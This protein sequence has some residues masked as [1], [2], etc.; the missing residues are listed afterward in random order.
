M[1][2]F[3]KNN[4]ILFVIMAVA[5]LAACFVIVQRWNVE[6]KDKTYDIVLDYNEL[7]KL[8][9]QSEN[10]ISWWLNKFAD[11]G[12]DKVG[13]TEES[14]LSLMENTDMA[15]TGYVMDNL[16]QN[17]GWE[18]DYPAEFIKRIEGFTPFDVMVKANGK[19]AVEFV[20]KGITER[21][22]KDKYISAKYPDSAYFLIKGTPTSTLY[23]EAYKYM[24]SKKGGFAERRDIVSSKIMYISLGLMPEKVKYVQEQGMRV[25][26]RTM[27]YGGYNDTQFAEA[28]ISDYEDYNIHPEYIIV[29]GEAVFGFDDGIEFAKDYILDNEVTIGLIENTTQRQNI[30]QNGVQEVAIA[31]GYDTVRVFS[32]WD[33][34]QYRYQYYGYEGAE[35]IENTLFRAVTERNIRVIYFKPFL[36]N[37]D[38]HTYI[39]NADEYEDMFKSLEQRL[40]RHGFTK[41][42]ASVIGEF[43]VSV[44]AQ[45]LVAIG[46]VCGAVLMLCSLF[47]IN[48]KW[49]YILTGLGIIGVIGA[50]YIMPNTSVL[51]T[52][53]AAAV[54]FACLAATFVAEASKEACCLCGNN[55]GKMMISAVII[56]VG[57]V[58]ISLIGGIMTAAPLSSTGFMLE[59]DI[60]RGVK[61][62]QLLP[63]AYGLVIYM[64]YHGFMREKQHVGKLELSDI[65]NVLN[66]E[67]KVWMVVALGCVA[68][69][70]YYYMARTGHDTSI[71][72]SNLEMLFRNK[73]EELLLARPRNKEFLFAFPAI[74]MAVYCSI[75]K[76]KL[77]TLLFSVAGIIGMTSVINTF[78]H[79]RTPLYL[80]F[81]RTGYSLLFGIVLG[82][83]AILVFH[84]IY[85]LYVRFLKDAIDRALAE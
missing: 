2:E 41:G 7:E 51:I 73:L 12:I 27:S 68:V 20:Y 16:I 60:Y 25:I 81:A 29:G 69:L 26:P 64:A 13:V 74:M 1:R 31:S 77:W 78:M 43:N 6:S 15:V 85:S 56:L 23:S 4:K 35:E 30:I 50:Y 8:A 83:I 44:V 71:D 58:I 47:P 39:T 14:I 84:C 80:G 52:S 21:F 48:R 67:I 75:R 46:A 5:I 45:I 49:S 61:F 17:A 22:P 36:E 82:L 62:A 70:G 57:T 10:D 79:I 9:E 18:K 65:K 63:L 37:K 76:F 55:L 42:E 24:N 40:A 11:M 34:I 53:F 3:L 38:L 32:V 66:L 19:A 59:F 72:P 33:Y 54:V 28:V